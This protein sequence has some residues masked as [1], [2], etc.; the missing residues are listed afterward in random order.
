MALIDKLKA[1]AD[2]IRDETGSTDL[3]PFSEMANEIKKLELSPETY[4]IV[5]VHGNEIPA[6]MVDDEVIFTATENDIRAGTVAVTSKGVTTGTKEIPTYVTSQGARVIASGKQ[7]NIPL[8]DPRALYDYTKLQVIVC[9]FNTS[10]NNSVYATHYSI[11][12]DVYEISPVISMISS[13]TKDSETETINLG[14][15]NE[16]D[17]PC[18]VRYITCKEVI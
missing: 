1:I 16:S 18:I 5:D 6:V 8:E 12:D 7:V 14:F 17:K 10:L 9:T 2:A 3:I 15:I 4:M 13:V 11:I